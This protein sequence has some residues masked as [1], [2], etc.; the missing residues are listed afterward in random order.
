MKKYGLITCILLGSLFSSCMQENT[1]DVS[2]IPAGKGFVLKYEITDQR[3]ETATRS[4]VT[5]ESEEENVREIVLLFFNKTDDQSGLFKDFIVVRPAEG[6]TLTMGDPIPISYQ[7]KLL[8]SG[9]AYNILAVANMSGMNYIPQNGSVEDWASGWGSKTESQVVEQALAQAKGSESSDTNAILGDALLMSGSTSI[10]GSQTTVNL[11]LIRAVARFDVSTTLSL[12]EHY[13]LVSVSIWNAY[14][15]AEIFDGSFLSYGNDVWRIKRFYGVSNDGNYV[16]GT[17]GSTVNGIDGN[18]LA[19]DI[20][21]GLY[22]FVNRV[23]GPQQNDTRTTCLI[24]GLHK[25]T[26]AA[27][28]VAYYRV[29]MHPEESGQSLKRNNVYKLTIRGV[30]GDGKGTEGEA[31]SG[32]SSQLAY[33]IN[34]WDLDDNGLVI[35]DRNS[36]LSMPVKSARFG[37]DGGINEYSIYTFTTLTTNPTLTMTSQEYNVTGRIQARLDGNTL[38][39]TADPMDN[40]EEDRTGMITF[41][42]AGLTATMSVLQSSSVDQYLTVAKP[43]GGIPVFP[44]MAGVSSGDLTVSSSGPWTA[45]L[46][47]DGFSFFPTAGKTVLQQSEV[48]GDMF[49]I[50]TVSPNTGLNS[51]EGVLVVSLDQDPD[52]HSVAI[53][54][55]QRAPGGITITPETELK[56]SGSGVPDLTDLIQ[57][58]PTYKANGDGSYTI[59]DWDI[60]LYDFNTQNAYSDNRFT[61]VIQQKTLTTDQAPGTEGLNTIKIATNGANN[62]AAT[63][64]AT[65]RVYLKEDPTIFSEIT[66]TQ[67]AQSLTLAPG[68][69]SALPATG[70]QTPLITVQ[71]EAG[72]KWQATVTL[73]AGTSSDGRTLVNHTPTYLD[74]NGNTIDITQP[75]EMATRFQVVMPKIYWPNREIPSITVNVSVELLTADGTPTGVKANALPVNQT[76]L[77]SGGFTAWNVRNGW[78][79]LNG[80]YFARYRSA[81]N[82]WPSYSF[83]NTYYD[84]GAKPTSY[85]HVGVEGLPSNFDWTTVES[86]RTQ[87]DRITIVTGDVSTS[88]SLAGMNADA[89]PL[90]KSGLV[91]IAPGGGSTGDPIVNDAVAATRI[92]KFLMEY[93]GYVKTPLK[94]TAGSYSGTIAL[95]MDGIHSE[96]T[97]VPATAVPIVIRKST[98]K[99]MM[100][101]DPASKLVF[102]GD[103]QIFDAPGYTSA[104]ATYGH[105]YGFMCNFL[106]Y[107]ENAAKYGSHFTDMLRESLD[108]TGT[109]AANPIPA[110]WD[111]AWGANKW[112][113]GPATTAQ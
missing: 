20:K 53:V 87:K 89:G 77:T 98:G 95:Q 100:T 19:G 81:I 67:Q 17:D 105:G 34:Y 39:V 35:Q 62:S 97:T 78:G 54:F 75:Q 37:H 50:W 86:F 104:I 47:L 2:D 64:K 45:K 59:D 101:I 93:G 5:P 51:R 11:T 27:G 7:G 32:I 3:T 91:V 84:S 22:A 8:T 90:H 18:P 14:P 106:Y 92:Y 1:T 99:P 58:N 76:A 79:A 26:E 72:M 71:G 6:E 103:C 108:E 41:R 49:K 16:T 66:L 94:A 52:N 70:G 88:T 111:D 21:G 56:F 57:V 28:Q 40:G 60:V 80:G 44:S 85:V 15:Q 48:S 38:F 46:Y 36:L 73:S 63:A 102:I 13:D 68:M 110:P 83:S 24:V 31:Y 9:A 82:S 23:G 42:F 55:S 112:T 74:Q 65:L 69:V 4:S 109:A 30:L 10:S 29:N 43:T 107:V 25:R 33:V 96:A 113:A 12:K 61:A